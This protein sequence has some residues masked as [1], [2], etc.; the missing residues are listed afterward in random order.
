MMNFAKKISCFLSSTIFILIFPCISTS[1]SSGDCTDKQKDDIILYH[2]PDELEKFLE[3]TYNAFPGITYLEPVGTSG[4]GRT[5][6][7]LVI[8]DKPLEQEPEPKIRITG[9]IHGDENVTT[10][11]IV[12][13]IEYFTGNYSSSTS[14]K[15]LV[16]NR[17]IVFI[18]MLNPDGVV[19]GSRYNTNA[20]DLNR[21]FSS[22]WHSGF[23]HGTAPFSEPES[24]AM[25]DYSSAIGFHFSITFH[26]GEVIVNMPF[27]Y[28][29][30]SIDGIG[31]AEYSL[32]SHIGLIYTTS[33]S[34]LESEGILDNQYVTDGTIN[35]GDWYV[36][37]GSLQDWSY[38]EKG[39]IDYTIEVSDDKKPGTAEEIDKLFELNRDSIIAF[40]DTAG[41]GVYGR[42]VNGSNIPVPASVTLTGGDIVTR[43]DSAG[44]YHRMLMPGTYTITFSAAGYSDRSEMITVSAGNQLL[45][46]ITMT[47]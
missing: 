31:P 28:A 47:P 18:P 10:E 24:S 21:N 41:I 42:V 11:M 45:L 20:V 1:C 22:Q 30:L 4:E 27:D 26:T 13:M 16:D 29:S 35:G 37:N 23:D 33:G 43:A 32:V 25:R 39:C 3:N 5:I 19:A 15:N 2:S 17:Y 46:N 44:Y 38:I 7:A 34:F 14:I 12:R 9:A 40:I 8:S 36:I 6:H